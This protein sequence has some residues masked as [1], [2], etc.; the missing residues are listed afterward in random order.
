MEEMNINERWWDLEERKKEGNW[1]KTSSSH[2]SVCMLAHNHI[3]G[4][5][6]GSGAVKQHIH[7]TVSFA[8]TT[9]A[10]QTPHYRYPPPPISLR[11]PATLPIS[12]PPSL[13]PVKAHPDTPP[14]PPVPLITSTLVV[15]EV[16]EASLLFPAAVARLAFAKDNTHLSH[17]VFT[18]AIQV[19]WLAE[20]NDGQRFSASVKGN[21]IHQARLNGRI[22]GPRHTATR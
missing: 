14:P 6:S 16:M 11:L 9:S 12:F 13:P 17:R 10:S 4:K 18:Q 1:G 2:F 19:K 3:R 8:R 21:W 5:Q 15:Q 22:P 20:G 7:K